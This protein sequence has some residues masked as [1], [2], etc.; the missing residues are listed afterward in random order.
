MYFWNISKLKLDLVANKLTTLCDLKYLIATLALLSLSVTYSENSNLFDYLSTLVDICVLTFGTWFCYRVNGGKTSKD[1][2]RRYLSI[3]W[4]VG[5][6]VIV[7]S[8]PVVIATYFLFDFAGFEVLGDA[9]LLDVGV[10]LFFSSF[11]YWRVFVH[12]K[13]VQLTDEKQAEFN[14]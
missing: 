1:F 7:F 6:R 10:T 9:T 14:K 4:V 2:L 11:F 13:Q 5:I 8:M 12:M 3:G